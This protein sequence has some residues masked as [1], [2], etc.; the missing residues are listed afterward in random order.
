MRRERHEGCSNLSRNYVILTT[1]FH[2][3]QQCSEAR[4]T[5]N[6]AHVMNALTMN[7]R[8]RYVRVALIFLAMAA[9]ASLTHGVFAQARPVA[10]VKAR[11]AGDYYSWVMHPEVKSKQ[12]GHCPKCKMTLRLRHAE[13]TAQPAATNATISDASPALATKT[14][15]HDG[16][17]RMSIPHV[18]LFDRAG[19]KI[20]FYSD[21]VKGRTVAIDFIFTTCT[22]ICPPLGAE[23]TSP[24]NNTPAVL[25]GN[26]ALGQWARTYGLARPTQFVELIDAALAGGLNPSSKESSQK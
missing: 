3:P 19:R 24:S 21:L 8:L 22:M 4:P 6:I 7:T 12:P 23:T 14:D 16:A 25:T 17:S 13:T 1:S 9:S 2:R 20:H 10:L 5:I 15:A 11:V 26:D 18:E